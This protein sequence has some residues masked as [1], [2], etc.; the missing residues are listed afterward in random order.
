M[1]GLECN[2]LIINLKRS[3][4]TVISHL[5]EGSFMSVS[6]LKFEEDLPINQ[7]WLTLAIDRPAQ[8]RLYPNQSKKGLFIMARLD[9]EPALKAMLGILYLSLFINYA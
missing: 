4:Y 9:I 6:L 5:G 3:L 1:L 7:V 2:L 8:F